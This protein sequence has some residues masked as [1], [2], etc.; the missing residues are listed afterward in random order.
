[1]KDKRA[2]SLAY[3]LAELTSVLGA[4]GPIAEY[5]QTE[6]LANTHD[7]ERAPKLIAAVI[8]LVNAR[9]HLL[10]KAASGSLDP[11]LLLMD[12]N[13]A[14]QGATDVALDAW[15]KNNNKVLG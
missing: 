15:T 7:V 9:L 4:A 1:M 12:F 5:V 11:A 14:I 10:C 3:E 6:Q 13:E 2:L 8:N